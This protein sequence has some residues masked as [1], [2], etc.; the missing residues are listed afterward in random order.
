VTP[1]DIAWELRRLADNGPA[2]PQALRQL[3]HR[4]ER[5]ALPHRPRFGPLKGSDLEESLKAMDPLYR[6]GKEEL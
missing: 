3:A 1:D 2:S 6:N 4:V 5:E